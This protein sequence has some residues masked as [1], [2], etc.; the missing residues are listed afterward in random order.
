MVA[1]ISVVFIIN[2]GPQTRGCGAAGVTYA[3]KVCGETI[4][5]T[6][7]RYLYSLIG[8]NRYP[9]ETARFFRIKERVLDSLIER[10][11]LA[12]EAESLGFR[13]SEDEIDREILKGNIFVT[14]P[15]TLEPYTKPLFPQEI[16]RKNFVNDK[17]VFQY[18]Q[19]RDYVNYGLRVSIRGYKEQQRQELL[20]RKMRIFI[21]NQASVSEEEVQEETKRRNLKINLEFIKIPKSYFLRQIV[22][23]E[24]KLKSWIKKHKK[25]IK[26]YYDTH[27]DEFLSLPKQVRLQRIMIKV[28]P[29]AKEIERKRAKKRLQRILTRLHKGEDFASLAKRESEDEDTKNQG[30]DMGWQ[31]VDE[32][33]PEIKKAIAKMKPGELSQVIETESGFYI[34]KLK[35]EREGDISFKRAKK[36]IAEKLYRERIAEYK[37]KKTARDLLSRLKKGED[38]SNIISKEDE[39]D[40][41]TIKDTGLFYQ[42]GDYIP[43]IGVSAE[44]VAEA[45]SLKLSEPVPKKY[46]KVEDSYVVVK[47]KERKEP[48]LVELEKESKKI[49]RELLSKRQ[50]EVLRE[51]LLFKKEEAQR[52]GDIKINRAIITYRTETRPQVPKEEEKKQEQERVFW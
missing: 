23:K 15:T 10:T 25:D 11:L 2:F 36:E 49:R 20:A 46:F 32:L 26:K 5:D 16:I 40:A 43:G 51:W 52:R 24:D 19:F 41:F 44:L 42:Q 30:G 3:A 39:S 8:G 34:V 27:K 7:F 50:E 22:L 31:P 17:G 35:A 9:S 21:K 14:I 45:F 18:T 13:V 29:Q 47:L 28:E 12:Q 37:A 48:S 4:T 6:A 33:L 38:I 1:I